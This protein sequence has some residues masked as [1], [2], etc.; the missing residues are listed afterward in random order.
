MQ[1]LLSKHMTAAVL[2]YEAIRILE[3]PSFIGEMTRKKLWVSLHPKTY[4]KCCAIWVWVFFMLEVFELILQSD[5][6]LRLKASGSFGFYSIL[7][8]LVLDWYKN[9]QGGLFLADLKFNTCFPL[10]HIVS[11]NNCCYAVHVHVK[12]L[13][14]DKEAAEKYNCG[15]W[16]KSC[17]ECYLKLLERNFSK[18]FLD[19]SSWAGSTLSCFY[20]SCRLLEQ[21]WYIVNKAVKI[22]AVKNFSF[23]HNIAFFT[24]YNWTLQTKI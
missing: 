9:K 4:N 6:V 10:K 16:S 13:G 1:Q 19:S 21:I 17:V 12:V 24:S 22:F 3:T 15:L 5:F 7:L 8:R 11:C 2:C 14:Q 18:D 20:F 23:K